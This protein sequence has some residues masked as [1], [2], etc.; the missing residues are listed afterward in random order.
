MNQKNG[1]NPTIRKIGLG[2]LA[3]ALM[4]GTTQL[5]NV[6]DEKELVY[7]YGQIQNTDSSVTLVQPVDTFFSIDNRMLLLHRKKDQDT[8]LALAKLSY[9]SNDSSVI[10][11]DTLTDVRV[12]P[13]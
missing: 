13:K 5:F 9:E 2:V 8:I 4:A 3:L 12:Y 1:K 6:K 10:K 11:I 7:V